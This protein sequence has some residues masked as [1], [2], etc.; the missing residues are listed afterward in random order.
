MSIVNVCK[1]Q[2]TV[3]TEDQSYETKELSAPVITV[4]PI[5]YFVAINGNQYQQIA[6]YS[7]T[8]AL[9]RAKKIL[10]KVVDF[11]QVF[12]IDVDY[13]AYPDVQ[14]KKDLALGGFGGRAA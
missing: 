13:S 6:A 5:L 7:E 12:P 8:D 10:G 4:K 11:Y 9:E 3:E 2:I 14:A 1:K